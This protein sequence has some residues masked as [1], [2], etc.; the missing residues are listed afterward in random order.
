MLCCNFSRFLL[1]SQF[2]DSI[3]NDFLDFP[4]V[5]ST[6]PARPQSLG[7]CTKRKMIYSDSDIYGIALLS[8]SHHMPIGFSATNDKDRRLTNKGGGIKQLGY[9]KNSFQIKLINYENTMGNLF[10]P[11]P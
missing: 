6:N 11:T 7:C 5:K 1:D 3:L 10:Y 9:L 4:L 8:A 2:F